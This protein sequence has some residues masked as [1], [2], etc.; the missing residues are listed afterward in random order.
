MARLRRAQ[1][2]ELEA[3]RLLE[4]RRLLD[5]AFAGDEDGGFAE[6]DWANSLGGTHVILEAGDLVL[7]HASVVPRRLR[8]GDREVSAGYVEAVATR[9]EHQHRGHATRVLEEVTRVITEEYDIGALSTGV[10]ALYER[11]GWEL[12]PGPTFASTPSGTVRTADDDGGIM[13]LR[14]PAAG[15]VELT[16]PITC[17]WREGDVW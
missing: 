5:E 9:P 17:D 14:T 12:W 3:A 13:V 16:D 10:P 11:Q 7:A 15:P 8:I 4:L 6:T 1:T 2:H